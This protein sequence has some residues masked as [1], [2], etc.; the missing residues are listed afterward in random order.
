MTRT[1]SKPAQGRGALP[2]A[3]A[4]EYRLPM[5]PICAAGDGSYSGGFG[6]LERVTV[7]RGAPTTRH[8]D[9]LDAIIVSAKT[10]VMDQVGRVHIVF[11]LADVRGALDLSC[12]AL[13]WSRLREYLLD[14]KTTVF[15]VRRP[16]DD[17]PTS[18]SV[19][20]RISDART[21]AERAPHQYGAPLKKI[22]LS[23]GYAAL[24]A[25]DARLYIN[26]A[27]VLGVLRLKHRVSRNVAR[28]LLTHTGDQHPRLQTVLPTIGARGGERQQKTYRKQLREDVT[29]LAQLGIQFDG[30]QLHYQR[31]TGVFI[32]A[33]G[34]GVFAGVGGSVCRGRGSV[35]RGR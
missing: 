17:W 35:C 32:E 1:A 20:D 5:F 28:W 31:N 8:R 30:K 15:A 9:I 25:A 29:G 10:A 26:K 27:V 23:E 3:A 21:Q 18:Y 34:A 6:E 14:L 13:D 4:L 22:V 19:I 12:A 16:G 11:D 33:T 2:T 7:E 24:L